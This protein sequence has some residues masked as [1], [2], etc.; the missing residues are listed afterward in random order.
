MRRLL[1]RHYAILTDYA[2]WYDWYQRLL[3]F[4]LAECPVARSTTY[5]FAANGNDTTGNGSQSLPWKTL[6]KAQAQITAAS[7]NADLRLRFRRGDIWEETTG[8]SLSKAAITVDAYGAGARP[9]FNLF[10]VKYSSAGWTVATGDRYTRAEANDI[11][12]VRD[13]SDRLGVVYKRVASTADVESTPLSF[14]WTSGTLHINAGAGT[15]P[16]SRNLEAVLSNSSSGVAISGDG[17]RV[18]GVRADGWGCHRTSTATQAQPITTTLGSTNAAL[19]IDCEGYYSG[20]HAMAHYNGSGSGGICTWVRCHAG[21]T[22]FNASGETVF[23]YFSASGGPEVLEVDCITEYGTLPSSDWGN[24]NIT[25]RGKAAFSHTSSGS[26]GLIVSV[27]HLVR[28]NTWGA[29]SVPGFANCP[30]AATIADARGFT[31]F[32]VHEGGHSSGVGEWG[33]M[34]AGAVAYGCRY[35]FTPYPLG[36]ESMS[37]VHPAGWV[38]NC[39][40]NVDARAVN[41]RYATWNGTSTTAPAVKMINCACRTCAERGAADRAG[42]AERPEASLLHR[43]SRRAARQRHR[44]G[45]EGGGRRDRRRDRLRHRLRRRRA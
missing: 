20:S 8:L 36:I 33:V 15:N 24:A 26:M 9:F 30:A 3:A 45:C 18:Q 32:A 10:T 5:Y 6:A 13:T 38:I 4:R 29:T 23:N 40:F 41:N 2:A 35:N 37:G 1:D 39:L 25:R 34:S 43:P 7:S 27:N 31:V 22:K 42:V 44:Q 19:V 11:A 28:D 17:C 16:N 14:Y 12:W 21:Y